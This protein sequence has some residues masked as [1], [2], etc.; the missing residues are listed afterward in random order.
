MIKLEPIIGLE[1]HLE[2]STKSKLFCHCP[3]NVNPVK[4]NI[5]ICPICLGHPGVLPVINQEAIKRTLKL[6]LSLNGRVSE[7][8]WF[9]RKNYFYPDLPKGYQISQYSLPIINNGFLEIEVEKIDKKISLTR[10]HLEE[11]TAKLIHS[12]KGWSLIDFNRSGIPLLE[13]VTDPDM[14]TPLEAKIFLQE[15]QKIARYLNIS[16]ADMEKGQMRCDVNISLRPVKNI[17]TKKLYSKT[18]IK[19]LNSFKAVEDSLI[20]EIKR[21]SKKWQNGQSPQIQTTRGWD[22]NNH[23]TYEQRSKAEEQDYRYFPEPDLPMLRFK[24]KKSKVELP[25]DI[26]EIEQSLPELPIAKRKRFTKMYGLAPSG[27]KILTENQGLADF[28][29]KVISEVQAWLVSL[30]TVEGTEQEIWQKHKRQLIKVITNWLINR[31]LPLKKQRSKDDFPF[32]PENFAEFIILVYEK[33]ISSTLAQSILE[34]MFSEGKDVDQIIEDHQLTPEQDKDKIKEIVFEVIKSNPEIVE[35]YQQGKY[36]VIQFL[37]GQVM[38]K[39]QGQ[40]D[41]GLIR[42]LL[43]KE[44]KI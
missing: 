41:P 12:D 44:L 24:S 34:R 15:L 43:E 8:C 3:N 4:P 38:K 10:I 6:G 37:V 23:L 2:L 19:N 28:T 16:K 26:K 35:K 36:V 20:Y 17:S 1:I 40:S 22:E 11:D 13:V 29:E 31:L 30:E 14:R 39:T 21:Q 9:D 42:T 7:Y 5:N 25:F 18:E 27:A 32:S 33:K